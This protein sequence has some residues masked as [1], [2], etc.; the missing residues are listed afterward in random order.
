MK[1][2]DFKVLTFDCYGT[3]IDWETG[4]LKALEPLTSALPTSLTS[5]HILETYA[6][7]EAAQEAETPGKIYSDILRHVYE[8]MAAEWNVKVSEEEKP[9]SA[10]LSVTGLRLVIRPPHCNISKNITHW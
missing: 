6:R 2:S 8:R 5:D 4:I 1:L 10:L 3:L 7:H 9:A